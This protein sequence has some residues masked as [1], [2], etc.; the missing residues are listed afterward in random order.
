VNGIKKEVIKMSED[1]NKP[2][3]WAKDKAGR[4]LWIEIQSWK[5]KEKHNPA[6]LNLSR[7]I[8]HKDDTVSYERTRVFIEDIPVLECMLARLKAIADEHF[9]SSKEYDVPPDLT[10]E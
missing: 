3:V 2:Y 5:D 10:G 1:K 6:F 4:G 8:K 7:K 9:P